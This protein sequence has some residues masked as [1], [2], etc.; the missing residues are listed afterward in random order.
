ML[1]PHVVSSVER[2]RGQ[3]LVLVVQDATFIDYSGNR[4]T[5]GLALAA[6]ESRIDRSIRWLLLSWLIKRPRERR[7]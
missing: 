5:E 4:A 6:F 2:M 3:P 1:A 7:A